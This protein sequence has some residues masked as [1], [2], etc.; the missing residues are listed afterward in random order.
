MMEALFSNGSNMIEHKDNLFRK[1]LASTSAQ[2]N[3][4][5]RVL[6]R[7]ASSPPQR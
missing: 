5:R 3:E 2:F 6:A 1:G 7:C 4:I